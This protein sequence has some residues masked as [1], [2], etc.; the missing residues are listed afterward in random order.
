[1]RSLGYLKLL[2][3]LIIVGTVL[4][5]CSTPLP[6][7]IRETVVV[8]QE[9][10]KEVLVM[11]EVEVTVEV[12]KIV[13]VTPTPLDPVVVS[14]T[15]AAGADDAVGILR[16]KWLLEGFRRIRPDVVLNPTPY[17]YDPQTFVERAQGTLE[18][19]FTVWLSDAR[20]LVEQGYAANMTALAQDFPH[21]GAYHPAMLALAQDAYGNVYGLPHDASGIGL[22]YNRRLFEEAGLDPDKPPQTWDKVREAARQ[23]QANLDGV[24]GFNIRNQDGMGGWMIVAIMYSFGGE[25]EALVDDKWAAAYNNDGMATAM[26]LMHDL[27]W[28]DGTTTSDITA[29]DNFAL[30]LDF[31]EGK[32]AMTLAEPDTLQWMVLNLEDFAVDEAGFGRMP[33]GG[34]NATLGEGSVWFYNPESSPKVK[35]AA[36]AYTAWR[37]FDLDAFENTI[38]TQAEHGVLVG[39]PYLNVFTGDYGQQRAAIIEKYANLPVGNYADFINAGMTV[40]GEPPVAAQELYAELGQV[41]RQVLAAPDPDIKAML[42][43]SATRF[44]A[45]VLDVINAEGE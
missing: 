24:D 39:L 44:Q 45:Q 32:V 17:R 40:R 2:S 6:E 18:D 42:D 38:K 20:L 7:I 37:E 35:E 15:D 21:L 30:I 1:M 31:V 33:D 16:Q 5:A 8:T 19:A 22:L 26:Q 13:E 41:L 23:I 12:E 29:W 27:R 9:T 43:A 28:I 11:Q 25:T 36:Y 34:A 10:E 3:V 4:A 14:I